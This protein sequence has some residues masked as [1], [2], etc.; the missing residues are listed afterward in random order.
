MLAGVAGLVL[1]ACVLLTVGPRGDISYN[2]ACRGT[3][4]GA[5][6]HPQQQHPEEEQSGDFVDQARLCNEDAVRKMHRVFVLLPL[7]LVT[8]LAAAMVRRRSA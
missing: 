5:Y 3:T 2:Q 7:G 1:L 8:G 4:V 6:L